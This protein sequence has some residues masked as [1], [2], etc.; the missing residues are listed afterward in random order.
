MLQQMR[1]NAKWIWLF[2]VACFVGGF[3]FVETSGLLGREQITTSTV[4]GEVNGVDIPYTAWINQANFLQQQ[5]ERQSGRSLSLDETRRLQDQAFEQLVTAILLEQEYKRRGIRVTDDEIIA[6]AQNSP[7]PQLMQNPELQTDGRFDPAK[8]QRLL[9]SPAA[10]QQGLTLQLENY[11]RE[12]IPK[13]KLQQ[14]LQSGVYVSDAKLWS[15]YRDLH[16][17]A[18]VSFVA[19]N[20]STVPD[21]AVKVTEA[22]VRAYYDAN[23]KRFERPGRAVLSVLSIPITVSAEDSAAVRARAVELRNE[24]VGGASFEDV[25]RRESADSVSGAQGGSLGKG[26][27]GRFVP[28]FENAAYALP[29]GQV[30]QP[31]LSP[32]GYHLIK[33]DSKKGDTLDVRHILLRI[34]QSDSSASRTARKA[35][36]LSRIAAEATDPTRLDSAAKVLNLTP[37]RVEAVEGQ[38]AFA[39]GRMIPSVSAWAFGGGIQKGEISSLYDSDDG[40]YLARL[41]SLQEGG[42]APLTEVRGDIERMLAE[43]KKAEQLVPAAEELSKQAAS[44]SLEAAASAKGLTVTKSEMFSRPMTVPGLGR[45]NEA[46]GA[47]FTLPVGQVSGPIRTDDGV[48]VIR[49]DKRVQADS[50]EWA[51]QKDAQRQQALMNLRNLRVQNYL[52]GLRKAAKIKDRR[53]ELNAAA[54]EQAA[55]S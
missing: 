10:R 33:V 39:G 12:E 15:I 38:P 50:A 18:Q 24:I 3:L 53:K 6:A 36:S 34:T 22:E 20:P 9:R 17:S 8:Y 26:A 27:K 11:Y 48:F 16:D 29:V 2:V 1:A 44:S 28:E 51:K 4:V 46:V 30:S 55:I 41:D 21:T 31:V 13:I 19:F 43:K 5:E 37:L 25:A 47:A 14:Q 54:R 52:E 45:L 7:P 40:Y 42:I 35:D 49:V 32:F 23:S